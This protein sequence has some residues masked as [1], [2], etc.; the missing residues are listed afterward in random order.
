MSDRT[1]MIIL[2]VKILFVQ[3]FCVDL[4]IVIIFKYTGTLESLS[5]ITY[6]PSLALPLAWVRTACVLLPI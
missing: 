4:F 5:G 3:F 6:F 2:V 1:I